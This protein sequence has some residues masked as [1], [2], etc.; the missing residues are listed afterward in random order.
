[1]AIVLHDGLCRTYPTSICYVH[2]HDTTRLGVRAAFSGSFRG[3]RLVPSKWRSLIPPQAGNAHRQ[4]ALE[5][6]KSRGNN[7]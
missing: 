3:L 2:L 6:V 4:P 7:V 5:D 1:M